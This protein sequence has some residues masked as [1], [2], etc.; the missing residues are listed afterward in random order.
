MGSSP[1]GVASILCLASEIARRS[2]HLNQQII[3]TNTVITKIH[4]DT[5]VNQLPEAAKEAAHRTTETAKEWYQSAALKTSDTLAT[6]KDYVRRN[7]LP[8][9]LGAVAFGA[10][11]C[12]TLM[13]TRR[14]P[15]FGERFADESLDTVREA[16]LG[17]L[18][19]MAQVVHDG[20]DSARDS[21][22]KAMHQAHGFGIQ[23]TCGNLSDRLCR[24]GSNL[25]FW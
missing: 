5:L 12:Y 16:I 6:S 14:K 21:V 25:K 22:G 20:Y 23:R 2:T 18:T 4:P 17:A 15:T 19:P 9:V 7:P 24:V 8:V 13:H 10:T 11:I 3:H 1:H